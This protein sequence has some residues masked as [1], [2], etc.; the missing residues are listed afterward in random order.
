MKAALQQAAPESDPD[1]WN[2]SGTVLYTLQYPPTLVHRSLRH[3]S[4]LSTL[5][6]AA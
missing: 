1:S 5:L 3:R 2:T 6:R 4:A